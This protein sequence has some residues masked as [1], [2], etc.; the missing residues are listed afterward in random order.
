MNNVFVEEV[1]LEGH[2]ELHKQIQGILQFIQCMTVS[3]SIS[4]PKIRKIN[5]QRIH[6]LIQKMSMLKTLAHR[7]N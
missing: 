5:L 7:S 2:M 6:L 4:L 3:L 1:S